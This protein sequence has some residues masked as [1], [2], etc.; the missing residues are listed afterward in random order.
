MQMVIKMAVVYR[1]IAV[2]ALATMLL[3]PSL[4]LAQNNNNQPT[5]PTKSSDQKPDDQKPDAPSES[6]NKEIAKVL[7]G[8]QGVVW[9]DSRE[10]TIK[11][12]S[13][14]FTPNKSET[15][16]THLVFDGGKLAGESVDDIYA[17]MTDEGFTK[18]NVYFE[19]PDEQE[20]FHQY[21][22]MKE[23]LIKKYGE[24][25]NDF[26]F[27]KDPY[28]KGDGYE[29]QAIRLGKATFAAYWEFP[30][31]DGKSTDSLSIEIKTTLQVMVSYENGPMMDRY[32]AK[33]K[34]KDSGDL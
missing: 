8:F 17:L 1:T 14:K 12:L 32:I 7:T 30:D 23:L 25:K 9:G 4:L 22:H 29:T 10:T 21:D 24:P 26:A 3:H 15:D 18:A 16:A 5:T 28:Y 6:E 34:D 31:K 33:K 20:I 27:F 11:V 13:Q 2:G 19:K